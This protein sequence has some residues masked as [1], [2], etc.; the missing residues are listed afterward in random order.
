MAQSNDRKQRLD[1]TGSLSQRQYRDYGSD[2]PWIRVLAERDRYLILHL[3]QP[4]HEVLHGDWL[5]M[6]ADL[7]TTQLVAN[8]F[9]VGSGS[10]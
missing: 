4:Y 1:S 5:A 3:P 8:V 6:N 7:L 9:G 2:P 10:E